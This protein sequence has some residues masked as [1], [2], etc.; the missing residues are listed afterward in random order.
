[1]KS[2]SIFHFRVR[3]FVSALALLIV[4]NG[5]AQ[6]GGNRL[7]NLGSSSSGSASGTGSNSASSQTVTAATTATFQAVQTTALAQRAQASLQASLAALQAQQ[8]AQSAARAATLTM[9]STVPNGLVIG[10]LVPGSGLVSPGI[11]N[12]VTTWVNANTPTQS[13]SNGQTKVTIVQTAQQALLNWQTFNIGANTTLNFDQSEGGANVS[14][15]VAINKVAANIAPS[16]ILGSIEAPGQV[17]VINQNGI[18]FGGASQVNVGALVASSLPINDNL[19]NRG[20]LNNPDDQFLFSQLNIAAG[21]QGPTPAFTPQPAPSTGT[22]AKTDA[23]GNLSLVPANGED[24]DVV[25]QTGAQISSP[26]TAE[27]VGG[28]VALIGPNVANAGTI[29]TPDGQTILAAGNQV[30]FAA[31]DSNDPTLRGLDVY[32]GAVDSSS[33]TVSN[34]GLIDSPEADITLA[35]KNVNQNGVI[36]SSTSVSLNGR[37]DL[38]ADYNS[39]VSVPSGTTTPVIT[40]SSTDGVVTLGQGSVTQILPELSSTDTVVGT[41]LALSSIVN[42]QGGSISLDQNA[43]LWAPG[44]A[45]PAD[46]TKPALGVAG[47]TLS[48]GVTLNAG[49]WLA[50]SGAYS[51]F[52]TTGQINLAQGSTIDVSG[53]ENVAASV[54]ENIVSAQLLGTELANS[55]VQQNGPLRGQT[56]EVD[57][58]QTGVNADGTTWIGT[59]LADVSGYVNLVQHTVGE[60]TTSG[61]T[62]SLNAGQSVNLQS[63]ST[64]NVSGGWI[65]Y[66]GG[67]VQTTKVVANGQ[68]LDISKAAPNIVYDGIYTGYTSAS[69]KWGVS[70]TYGNSL[71]SG[72]QYEAGYIQGGNG[73]SLSITAPAMTV[74]GS[75]YGNTVAGPYQRTLA[76]QLSTTYAGASYL[77]T[78]LATQALPQAGALTLNFQ[79]QNATITGYPVYSPTPPKIDFGTNQGAGDLVLS[80]DLINADGFGNFTINNGDGSIYIPA[81]VALTTSAGGSI[82]LSAA[83]LDIEG[84]LTAAG[85]QLNLTTYDYSPYAD[86]VSP[87]T[88]LSLLDT[89]AVDPT[90]GQFK[91]GSTAS[92]S[93]AGLILDDRS[94]SATAGTQPLATNGG[95]IKINSFSAN[96]AQGSAI[97]VSGGVEVSGTSKVSY[98]NGGTLSII[99]GQDPGI[100]SLVGGQL[101]LGASLQGYSGNKGGSLTIQAPLIQI[102]GAAAD[103]ANTLLLTPG[104]F[105]EGGFASF[106]LDGMGE[107]APN[108]SD[109]SLF[110]PAV[111]IAPNVTID[112]VAQNWVATLSNNGVGLTAMTLPLASE[113]TPVSLTFGAE[114]VVNHGGGLVVRG[115]FVLGTGAI[116]ETDPQGSIAISGSTADVLGSIIAPGGKITVS[117]AKNSNGLLFPDTIDPLETVDLGPNSLLSTSGV[118]ELTH[119]AYGYT[120][121]S[122]LPGGTISLSGNILTEAG[123]VL[124]VS[125]ASGVLDVSPTQVGVVG[126]Q[127]SSLALV[128]TRVD[129]N[130]GSITLTGGQELVTNATLLGAAG[131]ASAQG[132]S[133][134]VSSQLFDPT[135]GNVATTPLDATLEVTQSALSYAASGIGSTVSVNGTMAGLGY[136]AADS[137][138]ASGF[139]A[140][141]LGGTV[142]FSGP[143]TL[144]ANSSLTVGS[145]GVIYADSAVNLIAPYVKLGQAFQGPLTV[146]QQQLPI[147]VDSSGNADEISPAYGTGNITVTASSLIDVGNLSLQNIGNLNLAAANGDIRGDGTLD[148]AG[149]ISLTAGQ[150]YPTTE[151]TFTVAAY[152]HGSIAG[153]V[154]IAA[155]GARQ[156]PLSAGG[157]LNIFGSDISQG[158]VLRAPIGTIN[159]GSGVTSLSPTD[160]LSGQSFDP[161]QSLTLASGSTTSVSAVDPITGQDLTI[162]YGTLLNGVSWIDPAGNDITAAGNGPN[163]IPGKAINISAANVADQSGATIDIS[164]GGDLYAYRFVSG[165]GGTNDILA[166]TTSFAVLPGYSANYAPFY[167]A[168]SSTADYNNS[169]LGIGSQVYLSASSGLPAGV[170][171]LLPARYALL[172]GAFLVTPT[173]G[174]PPATSTAQPDG[175]TIVSGYRFNGLD[176]AQTAA[177]LLTSFQIDSQSVVKSRAEYDGYSANSFLSQ[178]AQA[179]NVAVPRLPVDAGQL[180]LAATQNMTIQGTVSSQVPSGGLGSQVDI[181]S[182]SDILISGPNTNLSGVSGSTLVLSSSDLSAFGADSLLIGGYRT[183]TTAGTNVTVTTNNL[184]VDNSGAALTGPDIILTSNDKLT[185][186]SNADVEQSGALSSPAQTLLFGTASTAG[187]G[188]GVLV[189]V[190]SDSSAQIIRSGVDGSSGP[191]LVIGTDIKIA[192]TSLILDSTSATALDPTASLSGSAVSINTGQI[193]LVLDNSLPTSGLVLSSAALASLQNSAQALSL[194][195][196]SSIDIYE[197]GTGSIGTAPDASGNYQVKSLTLDA[198]E[199]RGFDGGTVT[200]N[201]Q[202]VTLDNTPGGT[203]VPLGGV[204]ANGSLVINAG[205]IQLGG[206]SGANVLNIDG[207]ANVNFNASGG[208]LL[209]A[210]AS[211]AKDSSGNAVPGTSTLATAGA[212]QIT[213]PVITG[214]TGAN[215]TINANGALTINPLVGGST[216]TV[217]GGLGATLNL[218]G[219]SITENSSIQLPSGTLNVTA[220]GS[221]ANITVGGMLDVSGTAEPF[222]DLIEYTSGGK[223]SLTSDTGSVILNPGSTVTV[224]ANSGGGNAGSLT[225]SASNGVFTNNGTLLGQSGVAG[226]GGTFALDVASILGGSL[227]PLDSALNAGGFTQSISIRDRTDSSISVVGTVNAATYNLSADQGSI[228]VTGTIDASN[229]AATDASGNPILVGGAIDLSAYGSVTLAP[230]SLLTVAAQNFNN[231]GKGGS[232]TL[233]AGSET[234]GTSNPNAVVDIKAGSTINL[235]VAAN[236]SASAVAGDFTGTLHIRAP[237]LANGTELQVDPI[238]GNILNAS[239]IVVEGYKLYLPAGGSIDSVE[240]SAATSTANDGTVYGDAEGFAANSS[241]ILSRL[242]TGTPSASQASLFQITPGAEIISTTGDLTLGS[243]WDLSSFRF[244]PN[245]VAGVLTLRAAGNLIFNGS[246]SD[247]FSNATNTATLLPQNTALPV[248]DQSWSYDLV[249]GADLSAADI[250][251]VLPSME[252]YD[253]ATGLAV[254]GT[255]GGS[256]ELGSFVSSANGTVSIKNGQAGAV[257]SGDYQVIRT[258]SG[259]IDIA[260]A[261]DVLL[262]NQFATI[263]TAGTQASDLSNFVTPILAQSKLTTYGAQYSLAGGNVTISAQGNIAHVTRQNSTGTVILDSEKELPNNWLYRRGYV[264]QSS[265]PSPGTA[266]PGEFGATANGDVASTSWWVDFSNFFEGVGTLGGGNVTLH[267]GHDVSNVDAVAPTNSRTTYQTSTGDLLAADQTTVE[268]GGGDVLVQAGNDINAGAYYVE[269]GQGTLAAGNSIITNYTRSPSTGALTAKNTI[270]NPDSWLPTTFFLGEGSFDVTAQNNLL[271]GPVANPFLLPQGV[272]NTYWDKTYFSTYATTDAVNVTSLTGTV[273]L[274]EETSPGTDTATSLLQNWFQ[275]VDLLGLG[276]ATQT[277]SNFQPW[278]NITE[279][280]V[281]PF[282]IIDALLPS[283][284]RVTAFSG[285]I[286]TVGDLTLSPSPVGSIDLVAAGSI[287]G[288]QPNGIGSDG[289][290]AAWSSTTINLSDADPSAIPGIYDPFAYENVAGVT[291]AAARTRNLSGLGISL[292]FSFI[293][294]LFAESGSTQ[295]TY[296]VLQTKLKLHA[297]I[298]GQTLHANDPNPVHLYAENGDISGL[299]LFSG[300]AARVVAGQDLTD[301]ALYVQNNN[302]GDISL[303]A[304]GRDIIAYDANSPLRLDAAA[305]GNV[306][307]DGSATLAGDIQISGPGT[308]EV[309]AGRNLNLGVGPNNF[310][311]TGVGISSIGNERNPLLPFAGADIFAAAGVAGSAGFDA[312]KLDFATFETQ[313]LVPGTTESALYLPDLGTLLGLTGASDDQVWT[314]FNQLPKDEQDSLALDIFYLVLRDAGRNHNTGS[315]SGYATGYAAIKDLFH[316]SSLSNPWPYAGDISLTSRE[317]KTTNGGNIS[318]LAPGGQLNI[319]LNVAGIQAADQGI[320]TEDGGDIS[321]FTNGSV[322]VGTSRIFTLNGGNEIIWS[323]TGDIDAGASSKTVQSAPPTRV[324]VDPQS[325]AVETD[326]AGLATGGGIGVLESHKSTRPSDVDLVAPNGTVNAG[327]AGIRASGNLSIAAVQVLNAGNI[328]VG[329]KS[330][331]IPTVAAPNVAGLA[332]ASS[333]V[334]AGANAASDIAR[335]Q[336]QNPADQGSASVPSIITVEVLGY[337]GGSSEDD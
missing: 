336:Q 173:S 163:A 270:D 23:S 246:L 308:L 156:L 230:G 28:K 143:V 201:S 293:N 167:Q 66:Q 190:S 326:L 207:Y 277:V 35:G 114:G 29:S 272:N 299:T 183:S 20:L 53:S 327:D 254:P 107:V 274:R 169:T 255:A 320:L 275:N 319:G 75:L 280:S 87:L 306:L 216:A 92:L 127:L 91:L 65:N 82:T 76:S 19:I 175:S 302:A 34:A 296:G 37:I 261:G 101:V 24:G 80:S 228:T 174:A 144:K 106:T 258:G 316:G 264:V 311:G 145:S 105:D 234:N 237:Q 279:T 283:T 10:G 50:Y 7:S 205:T 211:A 210:T 297:S 54:A 276:T 142:Q 133:L 42:I 184:T 315:G 288:L 262:Q 103:P 49:S 141:T 59:P 110:L 40:P 195:S 86:I 222:N 60:L 227:E 104:F 330:S 131:G 206:G 64:V 307:D 71:A 16:Q 52:N 135:Q 197:N 128:P 154:T 39:L 291:P 235:S 12:P 81:D 281:T 126:N 193:S 45:V 166:S 137:F 74:S 209:A 88:G 55:P 236:T 61:G 332:A 132:G 129:S 89:P 13:T 168:N 232:V 178:S 335:Q 98:G 250:N 122:V 171:T 123:A 182:P 18:I 220:N 41:Q 321:I 146:A 233:S 286:N 67:Q 266:T 176:Q 305:V 21:T 217:A 231:A 185:L 17:Y 162:P 312:S 139:D 9:P 56:I 263:Y 62:V 152:D 26:A 325:G 70:Q 241:S 189:R 289:S 219:A 73:G 115:D 25:V 259:D 251:Q 30:A 328:Q 204:P 158:G 77:P 329:G 213:T 155:S 6:G 208:I 221:G 47:L 32:V 194:L 284:L 313:F 68:V 170:Y 90:R 256:L 150:I 117:G 271:L 3:S 109:S 314:A 22:V 125:G 43:L 2:I 180:V 257:P 38:L 248:N 191:S 116:I 83:N 172:P 212:L 134:T 108:Q 294:D 48:S 309:L 46:L 300:K 333:A 310:D 5:L 200:I 124:D 99:A 238:N 267:A 323:T 224:A 199:I 249:A 181:A 243:D 290:S 295:G 111:S 223:I 203:P 165:T 215:Q 15:W 268:L 159:L 138:N 278:L 292:D 58:R 151:T 282:S 112:P 218:G 244:G 337:G 253:P 331:G 287:N 14:Q 269:R 285:D 239:N 27:N 121:G 148:V 153:T 225:V 318:L 11:A 84:S 147:F 85:G 102:G 265:D 79:S 160:P 95:A 44:A 161:T 298:D 8:A 69:S 63:G 301:I 100:Q 273:T 51:F 140:L 97:D 229:V 322:N 324:L 226:E 242:L 113:R 120:T 202:S 31:H 188:D 93:V 36:N 72:A 260:T 164:G 334:G 78:I 57:L 192:G 240:G 303:V 317:I 119:N 94:T 187:S 186:D 130:G 136:F 33:G 198:D 118:V 96:L 4:V 247:G 179:D 196:Y 149:N 177:P 245:N 1:V 157:T 214:A 304:A 252:V